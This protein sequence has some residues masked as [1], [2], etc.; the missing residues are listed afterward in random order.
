MHK[1][2]W[3]GKGVLQ[4]E[5]NFLAIDKALCCQWWLS[6]HREEKFLR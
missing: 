6:V 1:E 4:Q 5:G 3:V 2:G